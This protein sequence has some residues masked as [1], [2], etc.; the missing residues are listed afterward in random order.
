MYQQDQIF[1]STLKNLSIG[2]VVGRKI[3]F[4]IALL[5]LWHFSSANLIQQM[6]MKLKSFRWLEISRFADTYKIRISECPYF[7]IMRIRI[8]YLSANR[9]ISNHGKLFSF[10]AICWM[11]FADEKCHNFWRAIKKIIF[12][13]TTLVIE[14]F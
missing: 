10:T 2:N 6:A 4:F 11:R 13:I 1:Y 3:I 7:N 14:R 12:L 8:L 9:L 5:K